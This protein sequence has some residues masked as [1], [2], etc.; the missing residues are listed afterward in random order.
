MLLTYTGRKSGKAFTTP[1]EYLRVGETLYVISRRERVWWRNLQPAN[2]QGVP[3]HL[4]LR[5]QDV[6]G[7]ARAVVDEQQ[8][9]HELSAYLRER[10]SYA[11]LW[12]VGSDAD[13]QLDADDLAN[14][15]KKLVV[16]KI[17]MENGRSRTMDAKR[18]IVAPRAAAAAVAAAHA[19]KV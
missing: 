11:K 2:V 15:A 19:P 3:V 5:G 18:T 10:P 1:V 14:A 7:N 12:R 4:R 17:E 6:E 16:V 8:V 13:G 9:A